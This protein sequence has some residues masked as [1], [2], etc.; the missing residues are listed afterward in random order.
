MRM[1]FSRLYLDQ[2]N[3]SLMV[4]GN[5]FVIENM[6]LAWQHKMESEN[7]QNAYHRINNNN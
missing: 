3:G 4:G 7:D 1:M 5:R 6:K 2:R